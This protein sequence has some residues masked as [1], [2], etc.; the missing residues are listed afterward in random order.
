MDFACIRDRTDFG[1]TQLQYNPN[2]SL[3]CY[4]LSKIEMCNSAINKM[5]G[6]IVKVTLGRP[7][8]NNLLTVFVPTMLL[9]T[10]SFAA[11]FFAEDYIDM[12][13]VIQVNLTILLV[14]ATM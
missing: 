8:I 5:K 12:V 7:I 6:I 3:N 14:L 4:T 9:V 10:I 11:R 1:L 2:I 13:K